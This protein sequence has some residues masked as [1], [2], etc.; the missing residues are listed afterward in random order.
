M[1]HK[2]YLAL[3]D[4]LLQDFLQKH[5]ATEQ[6]FLSALASIQQ[7]GDQQFRPF[8]S[9]LDRADYHGFAKMMQVYANGV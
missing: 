1:I 8:K 3:L 4:N 5:G 9:L 7:S 2:Q 6:E